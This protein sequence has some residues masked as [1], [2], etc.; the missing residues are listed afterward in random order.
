MNEK[1]ITL[2]KRICLSLGSYAVG[3]GIECIE[4]ASEEERKYQLAA[5]EREVYE[6]L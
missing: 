5:E 6:I 4:V 1:F 3:I 2:G